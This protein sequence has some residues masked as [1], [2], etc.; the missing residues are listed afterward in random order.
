VYVIRNF[1]M[2]NMTEFGRVLRQAGLYTESME[3]AANNIVSHLY[4]QFVDPETG[5]SEIALIRFFKTHDYEELEPELKGFASAL[6]EGDTSTKELKCLTLLATAGDESQWKSRKISE[7]HKAIPLPSV[8]LVRQFPMVSNLVKQFGLQLNSVVH[9]DPTCL[10][11]LE[12]NT[13][14]VFHVPEA[15]GSAYIPA[16]EE[17]VI[18]YGI[19][20][21]LGFGGILP[22]G[23]LF[24]IIMFTKVA[25]SQEMAALFKPLTLSI[26]LAVLP[27]DGQQVFQAPEASGSTTEEVRP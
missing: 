9:P 8:E 4:D 2:S 12:E 22:S 15:R 7:G 10:Q 25:V 3:E 23:N 24:A 19:Q 20:S 14:N 1:T 5:Q 16:Q 21:V 13:F 26:K 18:P 17:F 6:L 11:D 27:H